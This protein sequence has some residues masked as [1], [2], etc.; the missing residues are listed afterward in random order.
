MT[1]KIIGFWLI[2]GI[3]LVVLL[4]GAAGCSSKTNT[5][6]QAASANQ[7]SSTD[8]TANS[9]G[10]R[11]SSNPAA[12]AAMEI[13]RIQ[14][15][16]DLALSSDQKAKLKPVLNE[17]INT[18]SPTSYFLQAKADNINAVFT[19]AQKN[20]LSTSQ[21][22]NGTR[23]PPN[24]DKANGTPPA[25]NGNQNGGQGGRSMQPADIY[26]QALKAIS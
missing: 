6:S 11:Q 25:E 20:Y 22:S 13:V 24:G 2:T 10:Q 5:D 17:L 15:N 14:K 3:A 8:T 26:Q 18:A 1:K 16:T 23:T 19:D 21:N 9:Q 4:G 12:R 7:S